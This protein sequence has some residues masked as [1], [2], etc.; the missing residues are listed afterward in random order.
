MNKQKADELITEQVEE[1][2]AGDYGLLQ[3]S[4]LNS[5]QCDNLLRKT[6][7]VLKAKNVRHEEYTK[8]NFLISFRTYCDE[9]LQEV[10]RA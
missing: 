2:F 9:D 5:N 4:G 10:N 6:L 7:S 8:E 3:A 1:F